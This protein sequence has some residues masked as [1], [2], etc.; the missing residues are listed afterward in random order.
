M[1]K[2]QHNPELKEVVVTFQEKELLEKTITYTM[3]L[4]ATRLADE[5]IMKHGAQTLR[6]L[7]VEEMKKEITANIEKRLTEMGV[8]Q[9]EES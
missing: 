2:I 1:L 3:E 6:D 9:N 8:K 5:F 7:G 4:I